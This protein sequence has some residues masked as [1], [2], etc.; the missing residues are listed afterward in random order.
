MELRSVRLIQPFI[1]V[2]HLH[3]TITEGTGQMVH[4]SSF[5]EKSIASLGRFSENDSVL[6]AVS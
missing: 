4:I 6:L 2:V 1:N 3:K 5:V